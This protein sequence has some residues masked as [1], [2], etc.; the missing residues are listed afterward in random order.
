M[1]MATAVLV[2]VGFVTDWGRRRVGLR[3]AVR[4][5]SGPLCMLKWP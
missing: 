5:G 3:R 4:T 1:L 2:L